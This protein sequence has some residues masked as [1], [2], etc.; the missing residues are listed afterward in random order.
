M[1]KPSTSLMN[2]KRLEYR[3]IV[4]LALIL[5]HSLFQGMVGNERVC[6]S[7]GYRSLYSL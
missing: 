4:L 5:E 6:L 7:D 1:I 2:N 3:Y